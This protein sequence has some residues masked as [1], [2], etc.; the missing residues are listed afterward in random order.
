MTTIHTRQLQQYTRPTNNNYTQ[1]NLKQPTHTQRNKF[2]LRW[3]SHD[4]FYRQTQSQR[5]K[6]YLNIQRDSAVFTRNSVLFCPF[7]FR[8]LFHGTF[9]L[10]T[11]FISVLSLCDFLLLSAN[12][13]SRGYYD[14]VELAWCSH[15][16]LYQIPFLLLSERSHGVLG[17]VPHIHIHDGTVK[18]ETCIRQ[19]PYLTRL[20]LYTATEH[21]WYIS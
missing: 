2:T 13:I 4:S 15:A 5:R 3:T 1:H 11:S 9:S 18:E 21:F 6:R 10:S 7:H 19:Q 17:A 8:I 16:G 20:S 12:L 14:L